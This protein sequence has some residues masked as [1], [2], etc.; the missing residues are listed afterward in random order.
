MDLYREKIILT[1]KHLLKVHEELLTR[2]INV[3]MTGE[4]AEINTVFEPGD[5]YKFDLDQFRGTEDTN[6][7]ILIGFFDE[8][9]NM[10]NSLVNINAI[11]ENDL[12]DESF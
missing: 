5:T 4:Y 12:E 6:L 8:L 1:Y 7:K 9:E 3:G 10:M 11:T 2:I